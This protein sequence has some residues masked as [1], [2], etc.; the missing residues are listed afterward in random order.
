MSGPIYEPRR[1]VLSSLALKVYSDGAAV[2]QSLVLESCVTK[3][4]LT[5][6]K[7][8]LCQPSFCCNV[9]QKTRDLD[10]IYSGKSGII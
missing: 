10:D 2:S 4:T 8:T 5:I 6:T 1:I 9:H 7:V 3:T